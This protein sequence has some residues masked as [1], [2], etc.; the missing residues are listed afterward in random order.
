MWTETTEGRKFIQEI[1]QSLVTQVAP[2]E[3][4]LFDELMEE[5]FQDPTPPD[6]STTTNDD[7]L[8]FGL[9]ETLVAVTPAAAAVVSGMLTYLLTEVIKATQ[10]ET[11]AALKKKIKAFFNPEKDEPVPILTEAQL[12]RVKRL[13]RQQAVQFGLTTKQAE[14]M[15]NA[16]VGSLALVK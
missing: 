11:A 6:L 4:E 2:E 14:K 5:Y 8:G 13:A 10:E 15:S 7:P 1:S 3:L 9:A 12:E 16:L